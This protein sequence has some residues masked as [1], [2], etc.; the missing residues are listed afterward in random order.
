MTN[1][2]F[3][4]LQLHIG[5]LKHPLTPAA[6]NLTTLCNSDIVIVCNATVVD[7]N[8]QQLRS[9]F[10]QGLEMLI[11]QGGFHYRICFCRASSLVMCLLFTTLNYKF[12]NS[13]YLWV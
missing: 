7:K 4:L 11:S 2:L 8:T 5:C 6:V 1:R 10:T 3:N 13:L 12:R 9:T